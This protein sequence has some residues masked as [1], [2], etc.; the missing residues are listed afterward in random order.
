M[1][2]RLGEVR[3]VMLLSLLGTGRVVYL[4]RVWGDE[5]T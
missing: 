2:G 5:K 3:T 4:L 1:T